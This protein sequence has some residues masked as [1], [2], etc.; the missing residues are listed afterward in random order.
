MFALNT[1]TTMPINKRRKVWLKKKTVSEIKIEGQGQSSSKIN[2][3]RN[4]AK[5]QF[6]SKFWNPNLNMWWFIMWKSSKWGKFFTFQLNLT[7]KVKVN[8]P[9]KTIGILNRLFCKFEQI[10]W[11]QLQQVMSCREEDLVIDGQRER[12]TGDDNTQRPKLVSCKNAVYKMLA[13]LFRPMCQWL[14]VGLIPFP[15]Y[16]TCLLCPPIRL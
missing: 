10:W 3:D 12:D 16:S 8:E 9:L 7:L 14:F 6:W 11:L 1:Y 15:G 2:R 5:T 13:I 4:R